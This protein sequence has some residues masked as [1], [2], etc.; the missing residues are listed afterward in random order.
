MCLCALR[1]RLAHL[2]ITFISIIVIVVVVIVVVVIV[3]VVMIF[4][5][6]GDDVVFT[7]I[8]V[9]THHTLASAILQSIT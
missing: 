7:Y 2:H 9:S 6:D 3:V 4:G 8:K 1:S 5:D